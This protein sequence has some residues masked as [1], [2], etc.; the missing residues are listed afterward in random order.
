[1]D[2]ELLM[3]Q[4]TEVAAQLGWD[5]TAIRFEEGITV[6]ILMGEESAIDAILRGDIL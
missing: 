5:I 1:M 2:K 4:L 6:G 3:A